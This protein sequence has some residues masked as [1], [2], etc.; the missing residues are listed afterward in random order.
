MDLTD[1]ENGLKTLLGENLTGLPSDVQWPNELSDEASP[2]PR[3]EVTFAGY[4]WTGRTLKGNEIHRVTGLM[5]VTIVIERGKSPSQAT[6]YAD[7][8]RALFYEGRR[9]TI[10]GGEITILAPAQPRGGLQDPPEYR[11]PVVIQWEASSL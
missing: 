3:L 9:I 7:A 11:L 5:I 1:V 4:D 2:T 10:T 6:D 8:L